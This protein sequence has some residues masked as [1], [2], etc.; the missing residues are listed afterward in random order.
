MRS[1]RK[2]A[3]AV[4][5]TPDGSPSSYRSEQMSVRAV[6]FLLA[7][8]LVVLEYVAVPLCAAEEAGGIKRRSRLQQWKGEVEI[9]M[10]HLGDFETAHPSSV[11]V[12]FWNSK[13]KD[14]DP[15]AAV[16]D[17]VTR[18][19]FARRFQDR[20]A[21]AEFAVLVLSGTLEMLDRVTVASVEKH[22]DKLALHLNIRLI[23]PRESRGL[24][25]GQ[26]AAFILL[27]IRNLPGTVAKV[28]VRIT[29]DRGRVLPNAGL[30]ERITIAVR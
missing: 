15:L 30:P 16:I 24:Q 29:C 22:A 6:V 5:G 19:R 9:R 28:D 26:A 8:A 20:S 7:S 25:P 23:W 1:T 18:M 17:L 12:V 14:E 4:P 27:P 2:W 10:V 11:D 21:G 3:R 13:K